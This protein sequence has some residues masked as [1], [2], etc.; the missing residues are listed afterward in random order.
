M[1]PV[2]VRQQYPGVQFTLIPLLTAILLA[3]VQQNF[4]QAQRPAP[5][6]AIVPRFQLH[7][8]TRSVNDAERVSQWYVDTLG[9]TISDRF[10]LTRP[11]GS[12]VQVVRIETLG[13]QMNISEF[14]GSVAPDRTVDEQGWRHLAFQVDNVDQ[15]YQH[16]QASGVQF[17]TEPFTYDPPGYRIA[18]F[19]DP[20]GN[21][22]ELY[23]DL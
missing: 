5:E 21:I 13:L 1:I 16:L 10:T 17:L 20:E 4:V 7:H 8:V 22:L 9:F 19:R 15:T 18:F 2:R 11:N 12:Q 23:Q 3:A 14:D 6:A